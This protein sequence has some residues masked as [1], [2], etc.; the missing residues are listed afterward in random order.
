[1]LRRP[2]F[3]LIELLVVLTL[4]ALLMSLLLPALGAARATAVRTQC[5]ANLRSVHQLFHVYATEHDQQ[6]PLGYRGGRMQW[7]TMIYSTSNK[8]VLFG[9]MYVAGLMTTPEVYYCPAETDPEQRYDTPENRFPADPGGTQG[10]YASAPLVDWVWADQPPVYPRLD[11]LGFG[12]I[13]ADAVGQPARVDSRHRLGVHVLY[14]DSATRWI[15]RERFDAD[16]S[17]C[18][19]NDPS[20]NPFQQAI[21][22][23]FDASR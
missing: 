21:W 12:A 3:T 18:V 1:M 20:N 7:N 5:Q 8:Y 15:E 16:L 10:G 4:I 23:T 9:R 17:Q 19:G 11:E 13:F 2:A 6:V 14:A 22:A